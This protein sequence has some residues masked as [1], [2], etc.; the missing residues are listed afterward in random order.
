MPSLI[1]SSFTHTKIRA[2]LAAQLFPHMTPYAP[3]A[4]SSAHPAIPSTST[5]STNRS[6]YSNAVEEVAQK[7]H[8]SCA[9]RLLGTLQPRSGWCLKQA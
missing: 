3:P 5:A 1:L 2:G 7:V 9:A 6:N 4:P 8:S